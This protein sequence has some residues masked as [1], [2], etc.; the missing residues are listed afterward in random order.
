MDLFLK[1]E[2]NRDEYVITHVLIMFG[3]K[4]IGGEK[5]QKIMQNDDN[6]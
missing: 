4:K 5:M 6:K 2:L 1:K 3:M